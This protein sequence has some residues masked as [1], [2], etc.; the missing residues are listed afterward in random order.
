MEKSEAAAIRGQSAAQILPA[1]DFVHGLVGDEFFQNGGWGLPVDPAQ[2]EEAAVEPGGEEM[3][4]VGIQQFKRGLGFEI[5]WE[6]LAQ[7]DEFCGAALRHVHP[8]QQFL[9][10]RLCVI[11][12]CGSSFGRR[13]FDIGKGCLCEAGFVG[14]E[15]IREEA[16]EDPALLRGERCQYAE[17]FPCDRSA[18]GLAMF[19]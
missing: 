12:Q 14:L 2:F 5:L 18:G 16:V 13:C 11:G 10:G 8:A 1:L 15:I 9:A 7:G 3:F 6:V 4:E 19:G 17:Q